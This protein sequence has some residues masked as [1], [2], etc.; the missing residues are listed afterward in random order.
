MWQDINIIRESVYCAGAGSAF[1]SEE[2][3]APSLNSKESWGRQ[4][5]T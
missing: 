5:E 1:F 3:H 2:C 4:E